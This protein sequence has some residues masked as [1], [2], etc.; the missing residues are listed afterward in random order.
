MAQVCHL[1]VVMKSISRKNFKDEL[2]YKLAK[3]QKMDESFQRVIGIHKS[4]WEQS[5][6]KI[7]GIAFFNFQISIS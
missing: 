5:P 3:F 1:I 2:H 6:N 4:A 7:E